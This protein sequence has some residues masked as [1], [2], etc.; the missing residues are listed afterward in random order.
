M[1]VERLQM[2]TKKYYFQ[3]AIKKNRAKRTKKKN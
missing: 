2:K 3:E 1:R